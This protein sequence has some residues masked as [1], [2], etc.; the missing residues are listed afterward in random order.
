M[1]ISLTRLM[2]RA[3][4]A[5][6][7]GAAPDW[8][9]VR[10]RATLS[11]KSSSA[12]RAVT[13]TQDQLAGLPVEIL[14]P[15]AA[16]ADAAVLYLHGGGFVMGSPKMMRPLTGPLALDM[17]TTVYALDYRL[18]P[19]YTHPAPIDD[20][21]AAYRALLARGIPAER[22]AVAGDSA[23]GGLTL[24]L[25]L[26][27]RDAGLPAPAVLGMICP[28]IDFSPDSM[29]FHGGPTREPLLTPKVIAKCLDGYLPGVPAD[30]RRAIS[31]IY[32]DIT[33]LP[34]MV[35]HS[36]TD[37]PLS[38]DGRRLA[39]KAAKAGVPLRHREYRKLWHVFHAMPMKP[40]RAA[41]GD[42]AAMLA[43]GI[44]GHRTGYRATH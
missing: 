44:Y 25:G 37:D 2:A 20:A 12:P 30:E 40:A 14:T 26:R 23:G 11:T 6:W 22:I 10:R 5:W 27:I 21:E 39:D 4:G 43:E 19:E 3:V 38:G 8:V 15:P 33:G 17:N 13:V 24:E 35:L 18:A 31:P 9:E 1:L 16:P 34:P 32:Q 7:F 28:L 41:V 36:A 42:M 29:A